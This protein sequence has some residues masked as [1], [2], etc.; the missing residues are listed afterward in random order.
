MYI[1]II[2]CF[3]IAIF[4]LFVDKLFISKAC[5]RVLWILYYALNHIIIICREPP[6]SVPDAFDYLCSRWW[7]LPGWRLW[8]TSP[9]PPPP[10][11]SPSTRTHQGRKST[12]AR[13]GCQRT[14]LGDSRWLYLAKPIFKTFS[15]SFFQF[16]SFSKPKCKNRMSGDHLRGLQVTIS[17]D[18]SGHVIILQTYYASQRQGNTK[19]LWNGSFFHRNG[20]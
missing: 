12:A 5:R 3:S 6:F 16:F 13:L 9:P 8:Q 1:A 2:C 14:T 15:I 10:S 11:S 19:T 4:L 20:G 17:S 18:L 7:P